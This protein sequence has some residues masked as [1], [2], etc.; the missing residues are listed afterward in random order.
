MS[1]IRE[2]SLRDNF[3]LLTRDDMKGLHNWKIL[4]I[5][6]DH[7]QYTFCG[8]MVTIKE[9]DLNVTGLC[10]R[11]DDDV[12]WLKSIEWNGIN[13]GAAVGHNETLNRRKCKV[14][15][16]GCQ[17]GQFTG[18]FSLHDTEPAL[19]FA[20]LANDGRD[21]ARQPNVTTDSEPLHN[22][23]QSSQDNIRKRTGKKNGLV[24]VFDRE[25]VLAWLDR[26]DP[27]VRKSVVGV[28]D[29]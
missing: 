7:P 22:V 26:F 12:Q 28:K 16:T 14:E 24:K 29:V 5:D 13:V 23:L 19:L 1:V 2:Q 17:E 8:L 3:I 18:N 10:S 11:R 27:E 6:V 21:Y 25:V 9:R 15:I 20:F 4:L